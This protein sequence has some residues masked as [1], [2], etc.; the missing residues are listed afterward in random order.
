MTAFM[1]KSNLSCTESSVK[2]HRKYFYM[3]SN[4]L[5]IFF[6]ISKPP[7]NIFSFFSHFLLTSI[8]YS[9][10]YSTQHIPPPLNL[11][12]TIK[13]QYVLKNTFHC[14]CNFVINQF[15]GLKFRMRV[16]GLVQKLAWV[17]KVNADSCIS[18][19]WKRYTH[20]LL[21]RDKA[22]WVCFVCLSHWQL[23]SFVLVPTSTLLKIPDCLPCF[24]LQLPLLFQI[25]KSVGLGGC[26]EGQSSVVLH[27]K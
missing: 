13:W 8:L 12:I 21:W 2:I 20:M 14:I 7:E 26:L 3:H 23:K 15:F 27:I 24:F 1:G 18:A 10:F 22:A 19:A 6:S 16:D 9:F 25:A 5:W 4:T 17:E 11:Y